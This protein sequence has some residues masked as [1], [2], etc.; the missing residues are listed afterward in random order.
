MTTEN[1]SDQPTLFSVVNK[2]S[3]WALDVRMG[4]LIRDCN[5]NENYKSAILELLTFLNKHF[6]EWS[7]DGYDTM[8]IVI[9]RGKIDSKML[10]ILKNDENTGKFLVRIANFSNDAAKDYGFTIL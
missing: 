6:L 2:F 10:E 1:K 3:D 7:G 8:K 5:T 4:N 9:T